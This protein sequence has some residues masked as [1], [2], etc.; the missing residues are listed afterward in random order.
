[1]Y[2]KAR[3]ATAPALVLIGFVFSAATAVRAATYFVSPAGN[4]GAPG[5]A[6]QPFLSPQKGLDAAQGGDTVHVR[7][8]VYRCRVEFPRSGEEGRPITLEGE[9]GAVLDGGDLIKGWIPAPQIGT[10]VYENPSMPYPARMVS[11]NNKVVLVLRPHG[12]DRFI[13]DGLSRPARDNGGITVDKRFIADWWTGIEAF[14]A[15]LDGKHYFRFRDGMNPDSQDLKFI[16]EGSV[17]VLAKGK[18]YLV[19]RGLTV[20]NSHWGIALQGS[21]DCAV[22][23]NFIYATAKADVLVSEGGARNH[24]RWNELTYNHIY[25]DFGHPWDAP[26]D[27][28]LWVVKKSHSFGDESAVRLEGHGDDNRVYGNHVFR[29]FDG[30]TQK[31]GGRRTQVYNNI[32]QNIADDA[33]AP[34]G[35]EIEAQWHDNVVIEGGNGCITIFEEPRRRMKVGPLYIYRNRTYFTTTGHSGEGLH[36]KN[37]CLPAAKI[38][39]YHNSFCGAHASVSVNGEHRGLAPSE[40]IFL[41][42]NAFSSARFYR[43]CGEPRQHGVGQFDYNWC[44]GQDADSLAGGVNFGSHNVTAE[45]QSLWPDRTAP[46]FLLAAGSTALHKG[47]DLSKPF[48][49][50]GKQHPA[51]PGMKPGYFAGAA[52]D[53]GAMQF[54]EKPPVPAAPS[55]LKAEVARQGV[56]LTWKD[57]S[58]NED[59]FLVDR[60]EDGKVFTTVARIGANAKSYVDWTA[61]P[62]KDYRYRLW[63][64]HI[65]DGAWYSPCSNVAGL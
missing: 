60:S 62:G 19:V 41:L 37:Y 21:S 6:A 27:R 61:A 7:P 63:A 33:L 1:M 12:G 10:G 40:N 4:D 16:R 32:L 39:I 57:N 28:Y 20:R 31:S 3:K 43:D 48:E 23:G 47:L 44:G 34:E 24:V 15:L 36:F 52:P 51:L 9:P 65:T 58:D 45:G 26:I 5:T 38:Y 55:E 64:I 22:E 56:Q 35:E 54:G 11:W 17:V 25:P 46:S 50:F 8:G 29:H 30:I 2:E 18:R 59:F 14:Y 53:L 42:N 49:L 13:R